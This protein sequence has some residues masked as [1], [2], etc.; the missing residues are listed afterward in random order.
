MS[1][2]SRR[3]FLQVVAVGAAGL[4]V[5]W[6]KAQAGA[7]IDEG[8]LAPYVDPLPIPGVLSPTTPGGSHYRVEISEFSQQL[9]RVLPE[10]IVWGYNG[11]SPGP[12][13]EV[14]K[15][16]PITVEWVNNL[17]D[18]KLQLPLDTTIEESP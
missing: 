17:V 7:P 16:K 1:M 13:F 6:N 5:P 10:T 11:S 14:R 18:P 3:G 15:N 4:L 2:L 8:D 9:H 12:T